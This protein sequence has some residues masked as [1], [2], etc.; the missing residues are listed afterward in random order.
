[1]FLNYYQ[2]ALLM[3]LKPF[4]LT[5]KKCSLQ[6]LLNCCPNAL[7]ISF[8]CS[9]VIFQVIGERGRGWGIQ[10]EPIQNVPGTYN[11]NVQ[12]RVIQY[13]LR[14]LAEYSYNVL[15]TSFVNNQRMSYGNIPQLF[16]ECSF[17]VL[18]TSVLTSNECSLEM[19]LKCCHIAL[20]IFRYNVLDHRGV[21]NIARIYLECSGNIPF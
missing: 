19:L 6:M 13:S 10:L 12:R 11:F 1:M 14:L 8:E 2:N 4:V 15:G 5:I 18:K 9:V 3:F 21:G 17:A 7:R 16:S 20:G